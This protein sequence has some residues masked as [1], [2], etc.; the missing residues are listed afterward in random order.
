MQAI[1]PE[2]WNRD[3]S[4]VKGKPLSQHTA[5]SSASN[6]PGC[7]LLAHSQLS[8]VLVTC[9]VTCQHCSW[10]QQEVSPHDTFLSLSPAAGA[11]REGLCPFAQATLAMLSVLELLLEEP[12]PG[13]WVHNAGP[14]GERETLRSSQQP[15]FMVGLLFLEL[16]SLMAPLAGRPKLLPR[17]CTRSSPSGISLSSHTTWTMG[18]VHT[19]TYPRGD[20]LTPIVL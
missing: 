9:S 7:G 19:Q 13:G 10:V 16:P 17:L 2:A 14:G 1:S 8:H 6:L 15:N 20:Q 5:S 18:G 11:V 3:C 12:D 4:K